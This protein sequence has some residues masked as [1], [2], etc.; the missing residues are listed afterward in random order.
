MLQQ[1]ASQNEVAL[2]LNVG[3]AED[4]VLGNGDRLTQLLL[5]LVDNALK[6]TP[7]GGK[8]SIDIGQ[9]SAKLVLTVGDTGIGISPEDLPSVWDRFFKVD[10]AHSRA[11]EGTGLG[12]AI[13]K[14][15]IDRHEATAQ[16]TSHLGQGTT[17]V[18]QFPSYHE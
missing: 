7:P 18:I 1:R 13:A 14:E 8:V 6:Y 16:V 5:I 9:I 11:D 2:E 15:I 17:F 10:K 12:L 4:Y 3:S